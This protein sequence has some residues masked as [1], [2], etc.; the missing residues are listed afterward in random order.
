MLLLMMHLYHTISKRAFYITVNND[1]NEY[2]A[3]KMVSL[4]TGPKLL[5]VTFKNGIV[6]S[7]EIDCDRSISFCT[8][9]A[10]QQLVRH[11]REMLLQGYETI[12]IRT[13]DTDVLILLIAYMLRCLNLASTS[14]H[15]YA[16]MYVKG[17]ETYYDINIITKQV[18]NDT[19]EALP[20][21]YSF[22]GCDTVSSIFGKGKCKMWDCWQNDEKFNEL[23]IVFKEL[24]NV[25]QTVNEERLD[26]L[27]YFIKKVY[28]TK[29]K[30][31]EPTL[32][33]ERLSKFEASAN[34][35]LRQI[36]M[37]HPA[38][39]QH[40]KRACYQ[41]GYLWNE[42]LHNVEVPDPSLW[43]WMKKENGEFIPCWQ[44][45]NTPRTVD[46]VISTCTCK[47]TSCQSC[48]VREVLFRACHFAYAK[49]HAT[50]SNRCNYID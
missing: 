25:P 27:E 3:Q 45:V 50:I 31:L 47:S 39:L 15:A 38:L 7:S 33:L 13:V 26:M 28:S 29:A 14:C 6:T 30:E 10:D 32:A 9:E 21:F 43:G 24:G 12:I 11:G 17:E 16:C 34:N 23:N 44:R 5:I 37:S 40:T 48:S 4:Y 35:D 1:L 42:C 19:S 46:S 2:L 41:A 18:G 36:P 49:E 22:T 20:F 8:S